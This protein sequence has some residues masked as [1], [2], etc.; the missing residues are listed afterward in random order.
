MSEEKNLDLLVRKLAQDIAKQDIESAQAGHYPTLGFR[1]SAGRNNQDLN[2]TN[3]PITDTRSLALQLSV[4][5][6]EGGGTSARTSQARYNYVAA[7][8]NLEL[9]HRSIVRLVRSSYN[10][11]VASIST[12]RALQQSVVSAESALK[13]TEAGF[14]V[15]TR[16]I[17]DLLDST[18]NLYDRKRNL[19]DARYTYI[20]S[21]V[22]LKRAGGNLTEEDVIDINK[23]LI[24]PAQK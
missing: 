10:D 13:A 4:P 9:T 23:G 19:A 17:V 15:G 18:R 16:T 20:T 6:Y 11:V 14:D 1:A 8:E 5:I 3:L 22:N 12:I 7:S 21:V 24:S 2:S